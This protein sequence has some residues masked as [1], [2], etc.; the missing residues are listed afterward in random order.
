MN[1]GIILIC[2][3]GSGLL[4]RELNG[5]TP[6][7]H[8]IDRIRLAA[9][10]LKLIVALSKEK[11]DD[12]LAE[13]C[14][15]AGLLVL[16]GPK[17]ET[18]RFN[19]VAE[20]HHFE[21]AAR[22][23]GR[24]IFVDVDTLKCM[25]AISATDQ[26]DLVTNRGSGIPRGLEFDIL[27]TNGCV[28]RVFRYTTAENSNSADWSFSLD[29]EEDL[30]NVRKIFEQGGLCPARLG[31]DQL[32]SV[33]SG[34]RMFSPWSGSTGPLLIAEIGGNHEGDFEV[35]KMMAEQAIHSG[36]DCVKFQIYRGSSLVSRVESPDRYEHFTR[37]ELLPEQHIELAQIC[38]N[39]GVKYLASVW[40]TEM[41]DWIDPYLDFYKIGSGDLTAWPLLAAFAQRGKPILLSTGLASIEEVLQ[42]VNFIQSID[43]RYE[44]PEWLC[45]LQCTSM[46]PIPDEEAN[47]RVM[48][49]F[50]A[51]TGLAV[52]YSDHTVGTDAIC[53]AVALGADVIEFH[54]TDS[55]ENKSFR[56]HKVSLV[57]SEVHELKKKIIQFVSFRGS[58]VKVIQPS[59]LDT[60]HHISFRRAVYANR[61]I[62]M[63]ET[64]KATD[65]SLLRPLHGTDAR[66]FETVVGSRALKDIQAYRAIL[67]GV[68]FD[69]D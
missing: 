12:A 19:F 49:L 29:T 58:G 14:R 60:R 13:H 10:D 48:E 24:A 57:E 59:E 36:A 45:L 16:R 43:E 69:K 3:G 33:V 55:R 37:F 52:G 56:D 31:L 63:G 40:D 4:L 65:L 27:R 61:N 47:L 32:C 42:T 28:D 25:L 5:Q 2:S 50:R 44:R 23:D 21:M 51:R 35:A 1:T 9:P 30:L 17:D 64:I 67:S 15:R 66:D 34:A 26:F 20:H 8:I 39:H 6:F 38:R 53:A 11:V 46:Y 68:D 54:F 18:E 62:S 7:S 41:L 22:L